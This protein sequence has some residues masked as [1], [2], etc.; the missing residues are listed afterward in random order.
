L[1]EGATELSFTE[2]MNPSNASSL[3]AFAGLVIIASLVGRNLGHLQRSSPQNDDH[4]LSG[5]FWKEHRKMDD[6]LLNI[7][8]HMP[9]HLRLPAGISSPDKIF[10]HMTLQVATMFLHQTAIFKAEKHNLSVSII[11]QSRMRCLAAATEICSIMKMIA[12]MD[13]T[14]VTLLSFCPQKLC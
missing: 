1:G 10:L 9:S 7:S 3:S 5:E 2:A 11:A 12:H 6:I 4:D 13:L 8:L 14:M